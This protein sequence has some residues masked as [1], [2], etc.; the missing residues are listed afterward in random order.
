MSLVQ[1]W[2][3]KRYTATPIFGAAIHGGSILG[4]IKSVAKRIFGMPSIRKMASSIVDKVFKSAPGLV[5]KAADAIDGKLGPKLPGFLS[6][7]RGQFK[8]AATDLIKSGLAEGQHKIMEKL[9]EPAVKVNP[10]ETVSA[11]GVKL[12]R[13]PKK[14][15]SKKASLIA[16]IMK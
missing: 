14:F 4:R 5:D 9:P 11:S 16:S 15:N 10:N 12:A 1:P 6:S 3:V 7:Y 13:A 8:K 2:M